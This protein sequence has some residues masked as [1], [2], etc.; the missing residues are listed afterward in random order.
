MAW[1]ACRR[2]ASDAQQKKRPASGDDAPEPPSDARVCEGVMQD[3]RA[4][5]ARSVKK[6]VL[7]YARLSGAERA[8]ACAPK[9]EGVRHCAV[10]AG[11][12]QRHD[13]CGYLGNG[14]LEDVRPWRSRVAVVAGLVVVVAP[15]R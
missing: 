10:G 4:D 15:G 3:V 9:R 7:D 6:A 13:A 11:R 12:R 14:Y 8:A 1:A 5:Y 2:A